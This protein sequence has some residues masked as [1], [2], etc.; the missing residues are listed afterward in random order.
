MANVIDKDPIVLDTF[1]ANV[2]I[3]ST[4]I[5]IRKIVLIGAATDV[6]CLE[7]ADGN[8]I[9][10]LK[11]LGAISELD[12]G[13]SGKLFSGLIFDYGDINSGLGSGDYILIYLA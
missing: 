13:K 6:A 5:R 8:H 10:I 7:D 9:A 1:T 11:S 3:K 2:T 4:Q 12:F